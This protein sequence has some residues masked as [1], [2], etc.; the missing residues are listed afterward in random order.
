[1]DKMTRMRGIVN[2]HQQHDGGEDEQPHIIRFSIRKRR[3]FKHPAIPHTET[4]KLSQTWLADSES[5]HKKNM[6][7][8]K[9]SDNDPK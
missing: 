6:W 8:T 1:M 5:T 3:L 4:E 2:T 7:N 9:S